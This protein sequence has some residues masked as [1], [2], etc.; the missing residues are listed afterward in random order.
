LKY[1]SWSLAL[2]MAIIFCSHCKV[3]AQVSFTTSRLTMDDGLSQGSNYF[4][5]EDSKGFMW[6]TCNDALNR[7]DGKMVKVY[8]LNRYFEN[9]PALQQGYGFA[10]DTASNIYI[11]STRGLYI[12]HRKQ[13]KFTLQKIFTNSEDDVAMP[14]GIINGKVWCFNRFYQL[15]TYD[16]ITKRIQIEGCIKQF[17]ALSSVHIYQLAGNVFYYHFPFIDKE[18][19]IWLTSNNEIACFNPKTKSIKFPLPDFF[20]SNIIYSSNYSRNLNTVYI[21]LYKGILKY[22]LTKHKTEL[23]KQVG[24]Y[25]LEVITGI[26]A[27]KDKLIFKSKKAGIIITDCNL[28]KILWKEDNIA[29]IYGRCNCYSIDKCGRAWMNDNGNGLIIFDF[30]S[31]LLQKI[32]QPSKDI[33]HKYVGVSILTEMPNKNILIQSKDIFNPINKTLKYIESNLINAPIL[34]TS[35][36]RFRNGVWFYGDLVNTTSIEQELIFYNGKQFNEVMSSNSMISDPQQDLVVLNDGNILTSKASGLY[37]INLSTKKMKPVSEVKQKSA[38]NINELTKNRVAVSFLNADM[39][40]LNVTADKKIKVVKNILQG[41]QSFYMQEDTIRNQYWVGTNEG[42]YLLDKNFNS[43]KKID[44]NT[45]L[46]GTYIYGLLLDDSGN[47]W[48]SHQRGLSSINS[49]TFQIINYDKSDGIQDWDFNNRAFCK[50]QDG[51][52]YFGGVNGVNYFKPPLSPTEIYKPEVYVDEIWVN[53]K[54]FLPDSNA[55]YI[56]HVRLSYLQNNITVR[57]VVK[58]LENANSRQLIYRIL[59]KDSSWKYLPNNSLISFNNL[60]PGNYTLIMGVYDKYNNKELKQKTIELIIESPFYLKIWFW[61]LS[62]ILLTAIIFWLYYRRNLNRQRINFEQQLALEKQ[63]SKI[64]ADLHDDIGASLSSLQVNS[65][66]ANQLINKDIVQAKLVLNKIENQ[67]KNIAE[68]ISDIIWSMKPG[69]EEFINLSSR[70]KNFASDILGATDIAYHI[71][72]DKQLENELND[73]TIRKSILLITKEAINN[74]AKYSTA[75]L[76]NVEIKLDKNIIKLIV[77]DN[78]I[79]F[80]TA[81]INGNGIQNMQRRVKELSGEFKIESFQNIGTTIL[82]TIPFVPKFNDR[83]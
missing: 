61:V 15:A 64:T 27:T 55:N 14:I 70:I 39:L 33:N 72:I 2:I 7:Y 9:C 36:D 51:T 65:M 5:F 10:E 31:K 49:N 73:I 17:T 18:N 16:I 81:G 57:A 44:A 19:N 76:I 58:D 52:L 12:Y 63:R 40:L 24:G 79:G 25:H 21:G 3:V 46:A 41:V 11:G 38:F 13:D 6:I 67:A 56:Q 45:G 48:C 22:D 66:V 47:V 28:K 26:V 74:A 82:I 83:K 68:K 50:A 30:K 60:A 37:W 8:N 1:H 71:N 23:I 69:K 4:R 29:N 54:I 77:T 80:N 43:I 62:G 32:P 53:N 34:R 20:K 35:I 78:G 59:E 42:I 75:T